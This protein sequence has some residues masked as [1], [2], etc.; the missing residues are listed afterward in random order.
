MARHPISAYSFEFSG[1]LSKIGYVERTC[2]SMDGGRPHRIHYRLDDLPLAGSMGRRIPA[3]VA[4]LIDVS[5]AISISDRLA[6]RELA[7][8]LRPAHDRWH[9]RIHVTIPVRYPDRWQRPQIL[10]CLKEL[11]AF[12]TDDQW[13]FTFTDRLHEPRQ[14][15]AQLSY[16][17]QLL[18]SAA[19][20]LNSGGLD[21]LIGQIDLLSSADV[22]TIMPVTVVSSRR[23]QSAAQAV[24]G[25]LRNIVSPA[26][27]QLL[28][29][30]VHVN[31]V[32][33]GRPRD[34]RE[35]SHR[36]RVMLFLAAGVGAAAIAD[37]DRL[38]VCENGV[39]AISLPMTSDHWGARATKAMHPK[40]LAL[41]AQLASLA[42][43]RP[44]AIQNLGLFAT[45][46][47]LA[48]Q[49]DGDRFAAAARQTTSCDRASYFTS[50]NACGKCTSCI[51]RRA[52]LVAAGLDALVDGSAINYESDWLKP[53]TRWDSG[54]SA[55]LIAMRYQVEELRSAMKHEPSFASL[56]YA[57]PALF[58]VV[59]QAPSLD[60]DKSEIERRLLRL[61]QAHLRE[62]DAFVAKIDRPGWG[63]QQAVTELSPAAAM[64]AVS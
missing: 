60:L 7:A 59:A 20:I 43:D 24:V 13:I 45:K 21:S 44:I 36:G 56:E 26:G 1:G 55:H 33:G 18:P 16:E 50:G 12:I 2:P 46:G 14:A 9:R 22:S 41:F 58:E 29:A 49:L 42:L 61:Y 4:D 27:P 8:D 10:G 62:F 25:E 48:R 23:V 47:E 3:P 19:V 15:E 53:M 35:P 5:T 31:I 11:L 6:K 54:K 28:P 52:A 32:S 30:C 39:G 37:A 17:W 64:A 38:Y 40:T 63:R 34:D 51:L 57:F